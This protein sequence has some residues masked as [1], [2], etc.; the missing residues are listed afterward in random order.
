VKLT[1]HLHL[2]QTPR[3]LALCLHLLTFLHGVLLIKLNMD[4]LSFY[5]SNHSYSCVV[6]SKLAHE[7]NAAHKFRNTV[8]ELSSVY[9]FTE[10]FLLQ[11]WLRLHSI[12]D[13]RDPCTKQEKSVEGRYSSKSRTWYQSLR[14]LKTS[15]IYRTLPRVQTFPCGSANFGVLS[16]WKG[17]V[18]E[19]SDSGKF[20]FLLH[21]TRSRMHRCAW[22]PQT[23]GN[24]I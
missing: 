23:H 5:L 2:I 3:L 21:E 24:R 7:Q 22:L 11:Q 17:G 4:T 12:I 15:A 10:V 6:F 13:F 14:V 16:V 20:W 8:L 19:T 18:S 9:M 1:T